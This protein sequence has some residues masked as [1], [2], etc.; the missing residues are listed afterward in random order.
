MPKIN[1]VQH[2][3]TK[4]LFLQEIFSSEENGLKIKHIETKLK[5]KTKNRRIKLI[6]ARPT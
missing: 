3:I 6:S 5:A 1:K 2:E 4:I